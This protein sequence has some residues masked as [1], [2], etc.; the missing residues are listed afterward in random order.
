MKGSFFMGA[1][2]SPK[3]MVKEM[4]FGPLGEH[5]VLVENKACGV[6]G[7]DVHI[8][9][10]EKGSAE[11]TP[12]VVLGHEYAGVVAAVGSAV[13]NVKPGDHVTMDPNMYCGKCMPCRM[14]RKQNCEHLYA[15]GVN[16]NGGFAEYSVCPDTQ[17]FKVNEN[18][19]FYVAAM[20]EPLA[21]VAHG[22]DLVHIQPG[23]TVL[24]IGGGT[25]GL[26]MV[27]MAKLAGAS[28]VILS[29][30]I[31]MRRKIGLEVGADAVVDPVHENLKERIIEISGRDGA[32]AVI[33]CVG[34]PATAAQAVDAAGFNA[35]VLLFGVPGVKDT[36]QLPM[37]KVYQKELHITGSMIN[38]DTHQR[39]VNLI[40]SGRLE[41][42]KLITHVYDL[43]HLED[44][45]KMQ[46]SSESIKVLVDPWK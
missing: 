3:F 31:E 28:C 25:I 20:A 12:P 26:L 36:L 39:A 7:T 34:R 32:D 29:E 18:V 27:Q 40:N 21:C 44:A 11:V 37:F 33:E 22:I 43:E 2:Q 14:G 45:I 6:C 9:H 46:M 23:Q 5:E 41:I 17:C 38:P 30:P 8:Y 13:T 24:V 4:K 15:L 42:E 16:V 10:G 35:N 1:D 19:S